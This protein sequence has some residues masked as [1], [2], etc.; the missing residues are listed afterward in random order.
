M[1][2]SYTSR[3]YEYKIGNC[4]ITLTREEWDNPEVQKAIKRLPVDVSQRQVDTLEDMIS[5][6]FAEFENIGNR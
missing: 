6:R 4:V 2:N 5:D 1:V 3:I